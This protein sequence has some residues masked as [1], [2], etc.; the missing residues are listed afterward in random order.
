M[1]NLLYAIAVCMLVAGCEKP[2]PEQ[3]NNETI[4]KRIL[5]EPETTMKN[6]LDQ[7]AQLLAE[8]VQDQSVMDELEALSNE[9]RKFFSLSFADLLDD[10]K[11]T[12]GQFMNLRQK[13]IDKCGSAESKGD[14]SD[15]AGFLS[16]N[17]CYIYCPYP[18]DFYP[19]RPTSFTLAS[20]PIDN[21][22]ENTGYSFEGGRMHKVT[23]NEKY[24]DKYQVL[25]VMPRDE[26]NDDPAGL[27]GKEVQASK[28]DINEVRTGKVRC[29]A[30]CG[31]LFEGTLELRIVRGFP[32]INAITGDIKGSFSTVIPVNYPRDYAKAAINNWTVH[33]EGGWYSVN[34]IWDSNWKTSKTQQCILVYEYDKVNETSVSATVGYKKDELTTGLTVTAK[35]TYSG[36]FLGLSE[37]DRDWFFATNRNPG[38]YDE[39]KDGW[40]V[41]KTCPYFKLNTPLRV[42]YY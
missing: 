4:T 34:S 24:A 39:V 7:A 18:A 17:D 25:L 21:D 9:D 3:I 6:N 14:G 33:S 30:F 19:G 32:E 8:V 31:G 5:S 13:F 35:T 40:V 15:L 1:K 20:H 12:A 16:K 37:W 36:D 29:A 41:R 26:D 42:I 11:S 10:T 27:A 28:G 22:I 2:G 23:V 38:I